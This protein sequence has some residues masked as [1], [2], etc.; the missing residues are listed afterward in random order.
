[1]SLTYTTTHEMDSLKMGEILFDSRW[2]QY[3]LSIHFS[4]KFISS[5]IGILQD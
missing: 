3:F 4:S 2:R 5:H 1:M